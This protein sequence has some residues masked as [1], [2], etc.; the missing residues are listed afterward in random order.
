MIIC[1]SEY[2]SN[3]CVQQCI[4]KVSI[5]I[6][7]TLN[8]M[9]TKMVISNNANKS[10]INLYERTMIYMYSWR[11][12]PEEGDILETILDRIF[13]PTICGNEL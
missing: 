8:V 6:V 7:H 12:F 2:K 4:Q 13:L 9:H 5:A 11:L 10:L 3:Q 1:N